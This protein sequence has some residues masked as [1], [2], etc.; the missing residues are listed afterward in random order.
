[1]F[2][3][4]PNTHVLVANPAAAGEGISLH[5]VC[6]NAIYNDRTFNATHYLQS[7]DRIH[8]LGLPKDTK[9]N[10]YILQLAKTTD[11]RVDDRLNEKINTMNVFLNNAEII[12]NPDDWNESVDLEEESVLEGDIPEQAFDEED[13]KAII[14]SI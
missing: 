13:L 7:Q 11:A 5:D 4:D 9:T 1:M 8:R 3:E 12:K 10:I 6:H 2:K 14:N